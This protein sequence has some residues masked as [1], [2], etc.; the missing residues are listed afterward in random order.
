MHNFNLAFIIY[1]YTNIL[2][3]ETE[4]AVTQFQMLLK[5]VSVL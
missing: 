3:F 1:I 5:K 2:K 4:C